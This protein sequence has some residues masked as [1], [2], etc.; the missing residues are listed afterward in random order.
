[1]CREGGQVDADVVEHVRNLV[2]KLYGARL[3]DDDA[4]EEVTSRALEKVVM[5]NKIG[6]R[7]F[8]V[9]AVH[10]GYVS[11]WKESVRMKVATPPDAVTRKDDDPAVRLEK[12]ELRRTVRRVLGRKPLKDRRIVHLRVFEGMDYGT[13]ARRLGQQE[14]TMRQWFARALARLRR[15]M[16]KEIPPV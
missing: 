6:D 4:L 10:D 14:N 2:R 13:I 3:P 1:M 7:R 5:R 12:I 15:N 9:L 11:W 16:E 8:Y